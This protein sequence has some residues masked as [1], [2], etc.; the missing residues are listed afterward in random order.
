MKKFS[1]MSIAVLFFMLLVGCNSSATSTDEVNAD[2]S[3]KPIKVAVVLKTLSNPF[4]TTME[5]GILEEAEEL[6][7][8]VEILASQSEEDSQGQLRIFEDLINKEY[9]GIA[10]A[11]LSPVN[12]I[13]PT[14]TATRNGIPTV[15]IDEKVDM[16]ELHKAG[17]NVNAF[18]TT[19]NVQVG[20]QAGTFIVETIGEG[21]VAIV[22]GRSGNASGEA[23]RSGAASIFESTDGI[24]LVTS[25]PADW[26]RNKALDVVSN[27]IQR[28]PDLKAIYAAN[29]TMA[30]GALQ[31]V[32]NA[33]LQEQIIVVGTDGQPEA[34]ES[35]KNGG[36]TATVAQDSSE[37]GK[38]SL[39]LLVE[40]I[41]NS[42]ILDA[43][44][45]PDFVTV[46]S[47]IVSE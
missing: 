25:Q 29:D 23:R 15:N 43:D 1:L 31:A 13:S 28:Y 24:E 47:Y 46:S 16:D 2:S 12:L 39:R 14:V 19:D 22:E 30:L 27:M 32:N 10:F 34:I 45:E 35:V 4:W 18:V 3:E 44:E 6:G 37:I 38:E 36:L 5:Q 40:A 41:K 33:G 7:V 21:Q 17:G 42:E 26:D 9:D 8:E 20:E 11:P